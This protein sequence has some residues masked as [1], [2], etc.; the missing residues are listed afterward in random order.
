MQKKLLTMAV[1]SALAVPV[2]AF[3]QVTVYGTIDTGLRQEGKISTVAGGATN[4][5]RMSVTDGQRTTNRWGLKGTEDLGGGLNANFTLEGQ[6]SS[7]TG[8]LGS[9]PTGA[10]SQGLFQRKA[11][12]GLSSGGNSVDLGRDYTVN[13]KSQGIYDPMSYT[14]T[15]V[16]PSA[17]TNTAGVRSSNMV[18]AGFRFGT[19]GIRVD[20]ALG[21]VT[22]NNSWG[23]RTGIMGDFAFGPVTVT[24]ALSSSKDAAT[25][26]LTTKTTNF[27]GKY[28]MGALTFRA[29]T[30]STQTDGA[31][32]T[33][34]ILLGVQ[35]AISPTLN[36][37]VGYYQTKFEST[38]GAEVGKSKLFIVALDYSLSK[39]TT[40]YVEV[41]KRTLSGTANAGA[42]GSPMDGAT[43]VAVGIAHSF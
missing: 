2:V 30:S 35:Y 32:K 34:M 28:D 6:Y 36:G 11:I 13:F 10:T 19:G 1:A 42:V 22:A 43:A 41:D 39:R 31:G 7:D 25:G 38:G 15:G 5:S 33:P 4:G 9:G 20:Y 24:G 8:A 27:G 18:T 14:Y 17:G 29:G 3:A 12:V 26:T 21:E 16:T 40:T 23:T 37:R